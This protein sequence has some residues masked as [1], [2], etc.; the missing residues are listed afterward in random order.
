MRIEKAVLPDND[1]IPGS[2]VPGNCAPVPDNCKCVPDNCDDIP[3]NCI[4]CDDDNDNI[5]GNCIPCS[6]VKL[7]DPRFSKDSS[8]V[9][10]AATRT[11]VTGS[12]E[13]PRWVNQMRVTGKTNESY[14]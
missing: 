5:P 8:K 14:G 10:L 6:C 1:N 2:D 13:G 11:I 7:P 3:C 12:P 9:P 4:P